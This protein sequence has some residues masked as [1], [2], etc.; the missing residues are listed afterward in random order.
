MSWKTDCVLF[1]LLKKKS[2]HCHIGR[3]KKCPNKVCHISGADCAKAVAKSYYK[4]QS[5]YLALCISS[6][7]M[8]P[9][10]TALIWQW[11]FWHFD[12]RKFFAALL[13]GMMEY[14]N[15]RVTTCTGLAWRWQPGIYG[16]WL[17]FDVNAWCFTRGRCANLCKIAYP[18]DL[19]LI[20]F[21]EHHK[22]HSAQL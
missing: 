1:F 19:P 2:F 3:I 22:E 5:W 13:K 17:E 7:N 15:S 4:W 9:H 14:Q 6:E 21:F 8:K 12:A 10:S 18:G 11:Y 20:I 16:N